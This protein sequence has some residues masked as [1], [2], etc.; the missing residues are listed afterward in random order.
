MQRLML[1]TAVV[2][3]QLAF[4]A[5][6][7]PFDGGEYTISFPGTPTT[8]TRADDT[9]IGQ[10]KSNVATLELDHQSFT[11]AITEYPLDLV[12][13]SVPSKMLEGARD[14]AVANVGG[15]LDKD[16]GVFLDSGEPK[17]KWPGREF[18]LH[19]GKAAM[20]S[21]VFLVNNKLYSLLMVRDE[22]VK[23]DADFAKFADSLKLKGPEKPEKPA[24]KK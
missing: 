8:S 7:K 4:A 5:D 10:V 13:K 19:T 20:A 15:T 6:W 23:D 14:G 2:S 3:A 21:R 18:T 24:K 9:Q 1:L 12:K 16:F 22:T 17:K 11:V